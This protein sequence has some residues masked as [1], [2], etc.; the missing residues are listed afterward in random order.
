M[1]KAYD[2]D[3]GGYAKRVTYVID[4][5]GKIIHVDASVNTSSHASDVLAALGCRQFYKLITT[6]SPSKSIIAHFV[7]LWFLYYF[8]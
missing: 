2:V 3:G 4:G 6:K 7:A 8:A 5:N 1:I